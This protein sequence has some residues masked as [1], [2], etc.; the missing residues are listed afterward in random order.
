MK[1]FLLEPGA[2][3]PPYFIE[4]LYDIVVIEGQDTQLDA[5]AEGFP[6]PQVAW[7]KDGRPLTP[8]KEYK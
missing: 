4:L 8:N 2:K 1:L 6:E 3:I 5:C 7:E